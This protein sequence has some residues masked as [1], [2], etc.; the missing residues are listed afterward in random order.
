LSE[1]LP[2]AGDAEDHGLP[3]GELAAAVAGTFSPTTGALARRPG[4]VFR[5]SQQD[6]ART[7]AGCIEARGSLVAEAGTGTGKTFAYLVP[8]LLSG[9]RTLISTGTRH[10]Q[11]QLVGRDLPLL[12]ASLGVASRVAVLKGRANYVCHHHLERNLLEGSFERREDAAMLRR[13]ERFAALSTSGDRAEAAGIPEDAP[14]WMRAIST[15]E[16]CLGQECPRL[17]DCF[18]MRARRRAMQAD[19]V[20]VNHHLFC[21]DLA[22]RDEGIADLLPATEVLV[23]DEAHQL[24]DVATQFFGVAV[25]TR[26]LM[27]LARDLMRTGRADAPDADDWMARATAIEA[28]LREFRLH[29]G[30]PARLDDRRLRAMVELHAAIEG[31][32]AAIEAALPTLSEAAQRSRDL[33]RLAPR[34]AQLAQRLRAWLQAL[35]EPSPAASDDD[36]GQIADEAGPAVLWADVRRLGAALHASPLSVAGQ[37]RRHR[38]ASPRAWIFVSATLTVGG[39]FGHFQRALGLEDAATRCWPSPFD[40]AGNTRL[41]VPERIAEPSA[42]SFPRELADTIVPLLRANR[43]RAFVLCTSLRM[44]GRMAEL[45]AP[46]LAEGMELMVQGSAPRAVLIERFRNAAAPVLVGSASFWEGVDVPGRQLSLVVID[47][48]PFAPP[49]DPVVRARAEALRARG[50]DPFRELQLPDAAMSLKQGVGRLIRSETD[51]GVLVIGDRRLVSR[52]YGKVLRNSLPPFGLT[53][54]VEE[55]IG[56]IEQG[57]AAD[58]GT[59]GAQRLAPDCAPGIGEQPG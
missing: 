47:K 50:G 46:R 34:A 42:E 11:D 5:Q 13:I 9:A 32:A 20:V 4:Y 14:A 23:F 57:E 18:L 45:L 37:F 3:S 17:D 49:D 54:S 15:R 44:V 38:Q 31:L 55:V 19:I 33:G 10:L 53:R 41:L 24:P 25:S 12:A 36:A 52:P 48:L 58:P 22:L 7:I 1:A 39:E 29:A 43:G 56:F 27:E 40:Y 35:L 30:G 28:A 21:A 59:D 6:M 8:A 16:N 2:A 26:Q 51:R